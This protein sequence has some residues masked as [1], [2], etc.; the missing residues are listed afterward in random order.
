MWY[1][2]PKHLLHL[3]KWMASARVNDRQ[4]MDIP[5]RVLAV[6]VPNEPV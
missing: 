5:T 3:Y 1:H 4:G 6:S 2:E